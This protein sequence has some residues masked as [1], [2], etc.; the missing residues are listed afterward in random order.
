MYRHPANWLPIMASFLKVLGAA[1]QN[2][3]SL[4]INRVRLAAHPKRHSAAP[5][6]RHHISCSAERVKLVPV[7]GYILVRSPSHII[8]PHVPMHR[9]AVVVRILPWSAL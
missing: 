2:H 4:A 1:R 3:A 7:A 8:T 9:F 6:L 5:K